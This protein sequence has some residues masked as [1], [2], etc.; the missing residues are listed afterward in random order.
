[1]RLP[2]RV[3]DGVWMLRT[4]VVNVYFV[5]LE[6]GRWFLVDAGVAGSAGAIR[7]AAEALFGDAPPALIALTH[8]HFDHVGALQTLAEAWDAPIY[9]HQLEL[10]H[11][12]GRTPYQRPDPTAAPGVMAWSS[13]MYPR[14]PYDFGSR[15]LAL[16]PEGHLP[17]AP[18]WRAVHTPGHTAGHVSLF[19]DS[20]GV[21]LAGDAVV[22]T[23]QESLVSVATQLRE[24]NG[25]P[26]YFTADWAAARD[27]VRTIAALP[28][29][30]LATGHGQPFAGEAMRRDLQDLAARFDERAGP[31]RAR[32]IAALAGVSAIGI[33]AVLAARSSRPSSR[34]AA[35]ALR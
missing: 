29:E 5:G 28:V 8:G 7:G 19:R 34:Q 2:Q 18:A 9:A 4:L 3:T 6:D 22:T 1:M 21:L 20:D 26:R 33:A 32:S 10:P 35:G 23:R 27:S 31:Q 25:P 11:L 12:T 16:P 14:G 17:G 13:C 30:I 24:L 15:L